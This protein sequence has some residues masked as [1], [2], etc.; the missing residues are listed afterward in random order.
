MV[1]P[2]KGPIVRP[3]PAIVEFELHQR[4]LARLE[5]NRRY[6]GG[7]P[8]RKYLLRGP[9]SCATCGTAYTGG[10][11]SPSDGGKRYYKYHCH[12]RRTQMYDRRRTFCDC[13]AVK[14]EWLE[15]LV[16][17]DV[18]SFLESPGKVLERVREQ[19]AEEGEGK[20]AS[21]SATPPLH[22]V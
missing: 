22:G 14:A 3:V 11:S 8:G 13:P 9:V 4:A 19:L 12:Q 5:E 7:K 15:D 16:W 20:T 2:H 10:F 21:K 1:N 18:R 6:S 17:Q